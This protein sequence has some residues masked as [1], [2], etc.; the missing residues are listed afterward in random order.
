MTI[1]LDLFFTHCDVYETLDACQHLE[2]LLGRLKRQHLIG[3]RDWTRS[4]QWLSELRVG[5]EAI[6][7]APHEGSAA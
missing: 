1:Q 6:L 2:M 5:L 4:G 7:V 3:D